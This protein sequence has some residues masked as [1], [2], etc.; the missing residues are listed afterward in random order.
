MPAVD[1]TGCAVLG[2]MVGATGWEVGRVLKFASTKYPSPSTLDSVSHM[3]LSSVRNPWSVTRRNNSLW[4][5]KRRKM[6]IY[7][8]TRDA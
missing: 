6:N 8:K 7:N 4:K 2:A 1:G 5:R 3:T